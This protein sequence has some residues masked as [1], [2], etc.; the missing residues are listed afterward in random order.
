MMRN[1]DVL[2]WTDSGGQRSK[3]TVT[4]RTHFTQLNNLFIFYSFLIL[5]WMSPDF[6]LVPNSKIISKKSQSSEFLEAV[7]RSKK[8]IVEVQKIKQNEKKI[9]Q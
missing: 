7:R 6:L 4:S 1:G 3:V 8:N 9:M 5:Q 2:T